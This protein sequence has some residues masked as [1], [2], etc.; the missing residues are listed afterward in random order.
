MTEPATFARR[1]RKLSATATGGLTHRLIEVLRAN[2]RRPFAILQSADGSE[3]SLDFR[4]AMHRGGQWAVVFDRLGVPRHGRVAIALRHSHHL[5]TCL[6]GCLMS[7][8][9]PAV[10][11]LPSPK[12]AMEAFGHM[13]SQLLGAV[14]PD[15]FITESDIMPALGAVSCRVLLA[16]EAAR[17]LPQLSRYDILLPQRPDPDRTVLLQFSSGTTGLKKGVEI[18]DG[19]LLWQVDNYAHAIHLTTDDVIVSWLPLYHDMGLIAC[20]MM[21]LLRGTTVVSL[22]PFDWIARPSS[23]LHAATRHRA[24]LAWLPNF[25]YAHMARSIPDRELGGVDLSSLRGLVNCSESILHRSEQGFLDRFRR[26]GFRGAALASSYAMAENTFAVTS[27]GFDGA[28]RVD[29]VDRVVLSREGRAITGDSPIVSSGRPLPETDV[30]TVDAEG[31]VLPD[32]S[33]GEIWVASPALMKGYLGNPK[34]TAEALVDGWLRTDDLGYLADGQLYVVGRKKDIIIVAGRNLFPE[35]VEEAVNGVTDVV[36]GRCVAFAVENDDLGTNELVVIAE[37]RNSEPGARRDL[38]IRIRS[39]VAGALDCPVADVRVVDHMW[40]DKSTSGKISRSRNRQRYLDAL[41]PARLVSSHGVDDDADRVRRCVSTCVPGVELT[42]DMPLLTGGIIDS[43]SLAVLLVGLEESFEISL[44]TPADVG[45]HRFDSICSIRALIDDVIAERCV[46]P[47]KATA[48]IMATKVADFLAGPM[49]FD[50]LILGSS[51]AA[52]LSARTARSLGHRAY[53]FFVSSCTAVEASCILSFVLSRQRAP[54]RRLVLGVDVERLA[55]GP[56]Y[57]LL[58]VPEL[59][60]FLGNV[61]VTPP[62][63]SLAPQ[64]QRG[65]RMLTLADWKNPYGE[66]IDRETGDPVYFHSDR[67]PLIGAARVDE[68][69]YS[70]GLSEA[71]LRVTRRPPE[72]ARPQ[73]RKLFQIVQECRRNGIRLDVVITPVYRRL[74]DEL[75][76]RTPYGTYFDQFDKLVTAIGRQGMTLWDFRD[77]TSFGGDPED[78]LDATHCG[79]TNGDLIIRRILGTP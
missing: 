61:V 64:H 23:F 60:A 41:A 21:P 12:L 9:V 73:V 17:N 66:G 38:A 11:A 25:A 34:G 2:D 69:R 31:N 8:R 42:D 1:H 10:F 52:T 20:F 44:P 51:T 53:N 33:V 37:S 7:L 27:G 75:I 32:R 26:Y 35:D 15:L 24:T 13:V 19:G 54:L 79:P 6:I 3:I 55:S 50:L 28:P 29:H 59:T 22:S 16:D 45:F 77:V 40:L 46:T 47:L 14:K 68:R 4:T 56:D 36:P 39:A 65:V 71:I 63:A 70:D 30:V 76:A 78:F 49:D 72:L 43:L 62:S 74:Y 57:R 5:Y 18:T 58:D 67:R 48:S